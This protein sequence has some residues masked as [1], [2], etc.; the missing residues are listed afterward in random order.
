[1]ELTCLTKIKIMKTENAVTT[2]F[3]LGINLWIAVTFFILY[4]LYM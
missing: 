4:Y 2:L 3:A 1:M